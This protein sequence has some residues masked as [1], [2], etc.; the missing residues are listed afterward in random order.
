MLIERLLPGAEQLLLGH[1]I[2]LGLLNAGLS[3]IELLVEAQLLVLLCG[4]VLLEAFVALLVAGDRLSCKRNAQHLVV[5]LGLIKAFGLLGLPL[6]R[7]QVLLNLKEEV[8]HPVQIGIGII[9]LAQGFL[10]AHL[11]LGDARGLLKERAA[12]AFLVIEDIVHHL[13]LDD[14][15]AV[16]ADPRIHEEVGDVLEAA[17]DTIE[18]VLALAAAVVA[19]RDRHGSVLGGEDVFGIGKGEGDLCQ[20]GRLA[21][22]GAVKDDILHL[23]GAQHAAFLLTKHPADGVD[24]IGLTTTV[25]PYNARDPLIKVDHRLVAKALETLYFQFGKLHIIPLST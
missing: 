9:E 2:G 20:L 14:R 7:L 10:L 5:L 13:E 25:W 11:K 24:H 22:L 19:A 4:D 18:Q 16:A 21:L 6:Q 17:G 8:F 23:I 3:L 1:K 15:I 12:G